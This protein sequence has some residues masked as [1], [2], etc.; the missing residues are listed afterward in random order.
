MRRLTQWIEY[1][2]HHY[3]GSP[4]S[5]SLRVLSRPL[6]EPRF[7]SGDKVFKVKIGEVSD[8]KVI[9]DLQKTSYSLS[10]IWSEDLL[11]RE[12]G[13]NQNALYLLVLDQE[14]V[15]A[16]IGAWIRRENCH[17]SNIVTRPDYRKMGIAKFLFEQVEKVARHQSCDVF[18]LEV[19]QS[20]IVAQDLYHK[21]GFQSVGIK[22]RYYSNNQEDAVEMVKPLN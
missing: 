10:E 2:Y 16:F 22:K 9:E 19:R 18:T 1:Y 12:M 5:M 14:E 17:V 8:A 11:E 3:F 13:V 21:I 6:I 4:N 15:V 20:N 7:T